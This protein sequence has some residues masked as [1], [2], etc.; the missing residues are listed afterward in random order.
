MPLEEPTSIPLC[1]LF[2]GALALPQ[3]AYL[4][5]AMPEGM[6]RGFRFLPSAVHRIWGPIAEHRS[7]KTKSEALH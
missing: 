6:R 5:F 4:D 3:G 1:S 2:S 7:W